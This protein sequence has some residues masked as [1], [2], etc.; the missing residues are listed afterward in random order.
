M[1]ISNNKNTP[2]EPGMPLKESI[3]S[4]INVVKE[5]VVTITQNPTP[6]A[7][8]PMIKTPLVIA[9]PKA[10]TAKINAIGKARGLYNYTTSDPQEL[11]FNAGDVINILQKDPSGWWQGEINGKIGVFPSTDWIEELDLNG[12][13]IKPIDKDAVP[14]YK[15]CRALYAY[16][17]E[18]EYE[19]SITAGEILT[20]E[21]LDDDGWYTGWNEKGDYGRFPSNYCADYE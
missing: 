10:I 21:G 13:L 9:K 17:S 3:S 5:P 11:S 20:I 6:P 7:R 18:S 2:K 8:E 1:N 4:P 12:N 16:N 19:I 14:D 15:K